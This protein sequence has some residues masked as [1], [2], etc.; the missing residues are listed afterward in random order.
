[1]TFSLQTCSK[2]PPNSNFCI[3]NLPSAMKKN[4]TDG[5]TNKK[6]FQVISKKSLLAPFNEKI[7]VA[8][9]SGGD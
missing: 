2:L 8:N 6:S 9:E 7:F 5:A 4:A 3:K 1:M